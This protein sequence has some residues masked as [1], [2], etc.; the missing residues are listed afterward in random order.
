MNQ[1]YAI[2]EFKEESEGMRIYEVVGVTI[3][4]DPDFAASQGWYVCP[5]FVQ[6]GYRFNEVE[7]FPPPDPAA[8]TKK[9]KIPKL[10][11]LTLLSNTVGEIKTLGLLQPADLGAASP[12]QRKFI[13]IYQAAEQ[14]DYRDL[15]ENV[16]GN[17]DVPGY[18]YQFASAGF[19]T[20]EE[21]EAL[22]AAWPYNS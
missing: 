15:F 21:V 8:P 20:I 3:S 13:L 7:F 11:F 9:I 2:V 12:A 17:P 16:D 4:A 18:A 14:I 10:Q 6:V 5:D 1:R 19:V 22:E